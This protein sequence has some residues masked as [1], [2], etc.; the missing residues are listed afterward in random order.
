MTAILPS[1]HTSRRPE[2][3]PTRPRSINQSSANSQ[4]TNESDATFD[5]NRHLE[6]HRPP[7]DESRLVVDDHRPAT[8]GKLDED[9]TCRPTRDLSRI[10]SHDSSR[11][12][13]NTPETTPTVARS[14]GAHPIASSHRRARGAT[15]DARFDATPRAMRC[16]MGCVTSSFARNAERATRRAWVG[17]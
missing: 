8:S 2:P 11:D 15:R 3:D 9:T 16:E 1:I 7:P 4:S 10:T 12:P 13:T 5:A 17:R 6:P 14:G